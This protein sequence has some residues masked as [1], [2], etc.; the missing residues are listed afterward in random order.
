MSELI[1]PPHST[2]SEQAVIGGLMLRPEAL[3]QVADWLDDRD[4]YRRDHQLIF[5][6]IVELSS[7]GQPV[8]AVTMGEW[9]DAQGIAELVGG[10]R[11]VMELANSTP[12]AANIAAYAEIVREKSRLRQ[13]MDVGATLLGAAAKPR[14]EA[15]LVV[16]EAAQALSKLATENRLGGLQTTRGPLKEWFA[17]LA[18]RYEAN[19]R[20]TG[21][22]T[23]WSKLNELMG[24]WQPGELIVVAARP[25]MGKSVLGFNAAVDNAS[26]GN[27][28]ALFSIEMRRSAVIGRAVASIGYIPHRVLKVASEMEDSH[29]ARVS[30]ATSTLMSAPLLIDDQAGV[31]ETQII[32][33]A[34]REHLR[35]PLTMVVI[36]HLH[37]IKRAGR[38]P[39]NELGEMA[40]AFA[41]LAK[42][43]GV[44]VILLAQLNRANVGRTDRRPTMADLRA[45]GA[46][47]EVADVILLLHREDYYDRDTHLQGVIELIVG[48]GRDM[49]AGET[50]HLLNRFD[51][52]RIEDWNGPL[53]SP[54]S[55]AP[56]G[57]RK[58]GFG[59]AHADK[60]AE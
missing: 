20:M 50:I 9:F 19:E 17:D 46:I 40:R 14:A 44:P 47:E 24:G 25:N 26:R 45:S 36:D 3:T 21:L 4:F 38:D 55:K 42:D 48:K 49:P 35:A 53:P 8:D 32:A 6:A 13:A 18:R 57:G 52:M 56:S 7:R 39:V 59:N 10:S 31:T 58:R 30:A 28:T 2:E 54:P 22:T 27:R 5:R 16:S 23:P 15:S 43:L 34:K 37:H 41:Q 60:V 29:W 1:Q 11:Y 33:R 51:E 12:S